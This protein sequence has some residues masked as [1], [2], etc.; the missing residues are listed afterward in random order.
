VAVSPGEDF[1]RVEQAVRTELP[2][3]YLIEK[4]GARS[5][6]N[7]RMLRAF[8]W[9]LRVLGYISLVV[10]AFL[11]YNTISISVVR[12]RAEIGALRAIGASRRWVFWLFLGEALLFGFVGSLAGVALGRVMAEGAVRLIGDTV[13]SLYVSSRPAPVA[14]HLLTV[15][16]AIL[17]GMA[18]AFLS[19]LAPALEAMQV[20]PAEAMGRGAREHHARM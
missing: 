9:N 5:E 10:G 7:Q 18:V 17:V 4:P 20:A 13:N 3:A 14:L 1:A 12:R 2:P 19:A 11:I 16:G 8:R 15:A 6:E